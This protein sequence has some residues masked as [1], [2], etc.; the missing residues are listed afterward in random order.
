MYE[1]NYRC[2]FERVSKTKI[3]IKNAFKH[4]DNFVIEGGNQES[5]KT[6][7]VFLQTLKL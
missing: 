6:C 1:Q 3:S 2:F 4:P 5:N 7:L